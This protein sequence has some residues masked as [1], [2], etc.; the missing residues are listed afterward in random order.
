M[1]VRLRVSHSCLSSLSDLSAMPALTRL[2]M[3]ENELIEL[4]GRLLP[5][6][7]RTLSASSNRIAAVSDMDHLPRLTD[8]NVAGNRLNELHWL[9]LTLAPMPA[10]RRLNVAGN[11]LCSLSCLSSL[12]SLASLSELSVGDAQYGSNPVCSLYKWRVVAVHSLP[13]LHCLDGVTVSPA[14]IERC[15]SLW[16]KKSVY[17]SRCRQRVKRVCVDLQAVLAAHCQ[18]AVAALDGLRRMAWRTR[19][20]L[21]ELRWLMR[22]QQ[23]EALSQLRQESAEQFMEAKVLPLLTAPLA[24]CASRLDSSFALCNSELGRLLASY[25]SMLRSVALR[26]TALLRAMD[27]EMDSGGNVRW[28]ESEQLI[29]RAARIVQPAST[30]GLRL[31]LVRAMQPRDAEYRLW[32]GVQWQEAQQAQTDLLE[33][34]AVLPDGETQQPLWF[35]TIDTDSD[36]AM[37]SRSVLPSSPAVMHRSALAALLAHAVEPSNRTRLLLAC[38]VLSHRLEDEPPTVASMQDE[39]A[40]SEEHKEQLHPPVGAASSR[41]TVTDLNRIVPLWLLSVRVCAAGSGSAAGGGCLSLLSSLPGAIVRLTGDFVG[42]RECALDVCAVVSSSERAVEEQRMRLHDGASAVLAWL[43]SPLLA[44]CSVLHSI[45]SS[46]DASLTRKHSLGESAID[47]AGGGRRGRLYACARGLT[48]LSELGAVQ[49]SSLSTLVLSCNALASLR[50]PAS[51][52]LLRVLD[53]SHNQLTADVFHSSLFS[54]LP[55]LRRLSARYNRLDWSDRERTLRGL[56]DCLTPCSQLQHIDWGALHTSVAQEAA[57]IECESSQSAPLDDSYCVYERRAVQLFPALQSLDGR[58]LSSTALDC[59]TPLPDGSDEVVEWR[60]SFASSGRLPLGF[61]Y[62]TDSL[63]QQHSISTQAAAIKHITAAS[64]GFAGD[65]NSEWPVDVTALELDHL[66]LTALTP[67]SSIR[68][69]PTP[70]PLRRFLHLQSL[71]LDGNQ[72]RRMERL[73][74]SPLP[75]LTYLSIEHNQLAELRHLEQFPALTRLDASGNCLAELSHAQLH[76][77]TALTVV[78]LNNNRL[79]T[80]DGLQR[81]AALS[82]LHV[83]HNLLDDDSEWQR[84]LDCEHLRVI[85]ARHNPLQRRAGHRL[86]ALYCLPHLQ[87]LDEG[88]VTEDE[89]D[90]AMER[91]CG[92]LTHDALVAAAGEQRMAFIERLTLTHCSLRHVDAITQAALPNLNMLCLDHNDIA[93]THSLQP[94]ARLTALY[95]SNN[96]L[97]ELAALHTALSRRQRS[98]MA[99]PDSAALQQRSPD[100]NWLSFVYPR[101]QRLTVD[102]N[103]LASMQALHLDGLRAIRLLSAAAN[104]ITRL[105]LPLAL[106]LP[107]I[108]QLVLADNRIGKLDPAALSNCTQLATLQL[109]GNQL[110]AVP[111]TDVPLAALTALHLSDNKCSDVCDL[112]GLAH[113]TMPALTQLTLAGC[114]IARRHSYRTH[115]IQ[116]TLPSAVRRLDGQ[117]VTADEMDTAVQQ[118]LSTTSAE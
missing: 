73:T 57:A 15:D 27:V 78:Q 95:C 12:R 81:C 64:R 88:R 117:S 13:R 21:D 77:L 67:L 43:P 107:R 65:R 11:R 86:F 83:Q 82:E 50:L 101:L 94:H 48:D 3:D 76:Q 23:H 106:L 32:A 44:Q 75:C 31:Q 61:A 62:L 17:Y 68:S 56:L 5:A 14:E 112:D 26:Q 30:T 46:S 42:L 92:R 18:Q 113:R 105:D 49:W 98:G 79:R 58:V 35:T 91:H 85:D 111:A 19:C 115:I 54:F 59:L 93:S 55:A 7:L 39:R 102:H 28:E 103:Q 108:E 74:A 96:Q 70:Y 53:V 4:P 52:P 116:H 41:C 110:C 36:T 71:S 38:T 114:P 63:L 22:E 84:L 1:G 16:R 6:S 104:R 24:E 20:G 51:M 72:L 2:Y 37:D 25:R 80:L 69:A 66:A 99:M 33:Q 90:T 34:P 45:S 29:H 47:I 9:H 10:L 8:L 100:D 87:L 89:K 109:D 97:T 60:V 118:R 40:A